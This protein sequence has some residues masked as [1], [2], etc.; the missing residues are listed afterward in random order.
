MY[1]NSSDFDADG[2]DDRDA[3]RQENNSGS[4]SGNL[5]AVVG[6]VNG[7]EYDNDGYYTIVEQVGKLMMYSLV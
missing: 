3:T 5:S 7:W 4:G 2:V 6:C 1:S